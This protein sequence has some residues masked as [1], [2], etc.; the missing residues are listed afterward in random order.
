MIYLF[1]IIS[2][3]NIKLWETILGSCIC[4]SF[5]ILGALLVGSTLNPWL[6]EG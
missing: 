3:V 5:I 4:Y 6:T 2:A 1:D